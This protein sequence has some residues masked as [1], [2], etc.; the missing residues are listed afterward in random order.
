MLSFNSFPHVERLIMVKGEGHYLLS[1][2]LNCIFHLEE[3][4]LITLKSQQFLSWKDSIGYAMVGTHP[5]LLYR[6][7][8]VELL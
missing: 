8:C 7:P 2:M 4:I 6:V 5:F 3:F 1:L